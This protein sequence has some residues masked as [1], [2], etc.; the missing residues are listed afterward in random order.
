MAFLEFT[1]FNSCGLWAFRDAYLLDTDSRTWS[2]P[3]AMI[4]EHAAALCGV[5]NGS[6][7]LGTKSDKTND[8]VRELKRPSHVF[9]TQVPW[10]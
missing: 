3:L 7:T 2:E 4:G 9:T 10:L 5:V 1:S 8:E 6:D